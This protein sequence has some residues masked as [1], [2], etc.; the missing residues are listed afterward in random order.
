MLLAEEVL[1]R[2]GYQDLKRQCPMGTGSHAAETL[3]SILLAFSIQTC[4]QAVLTMW[5]RGCPRSPFC[6]ASPRMASSS[7]THACLPW[8]L[9]VAAM[10]PT[11]AAVSYYTEHLGCPV[12]ILC[13]TSNGKGGLRTY[14]REPST[15][16]WSPRLRTWFCHPLARCFSRPFSFSG[17]YCLVPQQ[18]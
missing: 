17:L 16:I 1:K 11:P 4:L 9:A 6:W 8:P 12:L 5:L 15:W 13:Y 7:P 2:R 10:P 18:G 14:S 3:G